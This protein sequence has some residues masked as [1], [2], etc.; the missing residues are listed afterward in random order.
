MQ[1]LQVHPELGRRSKAV[2]QPESRICRH[3][4][5]PSHHLG[6]AVGGNADFRSQSAG[7]NLQRHQELL[8]EHFAWMGGDAP[9]LA[10]FVSQLH[11]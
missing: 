4:S 5:A 7:A 8:L 3:A 1:H 10:D 6:Q 9:S 11:S 2:R